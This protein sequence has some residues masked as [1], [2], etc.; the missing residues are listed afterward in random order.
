MLG[1]V[2]KNVPADKIAVHCHDTY[3]QALA[4]IQ[5]ALDVGIKYLR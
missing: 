3:G 1:V 4:N 5:R 2:L